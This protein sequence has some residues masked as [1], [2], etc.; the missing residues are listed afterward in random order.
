MAD[1]PN[2]QSSILRR[3]REVIKTF[4]LDVV[5][6]C[7]SKIERITNSS[8]ASRL[9][10]FV[11]TSRQPMLKLVKAL[12][13]CVPLLLTLTTINSQDMQKEAEQAE[14]SYKSVE[15]GLVSAAHQAR[16]HALRQ[17]AFVCT[18][19]V[20]ENTIHNEFVSALLVSPRRYAPYL[21]PAR[22][23][24]IEE[25]QRYNSE[26]NDRPPAEDFALL[27][28]GL[29]RL[30]P[31]GWI[32]GSPGKDTFDTSVNVSW[33][34]E[35]WEKHLATLD[36][37]NSFHLDTLQ[38]AFSQLTLNDLKLPPSSN[39]TGADFEQTTFVAAKLPK[40]DLAAAVLQATDFS[41]TD[42][43]EGH[44]EASQLQGARLAG[45][46]LYGSY[47]NGAYLSSA[48]FQNAQLGGAHLQQAI[49]RGG[50][51]FSKSVLR[52]AELD[53]IDC[54][55]CR[56]AGADLQGASL[57]SALLTGVTFEGA[58]LRNATFR[59]SDLRRVR[60]RHSDLTGADFERVDLRYADFTNVRGVLH[61]RSWRNA[62]IASATGLSAQLK[63]TLLTRFHAVSISS[64]AGWQFYRNNGFPYDGRQN[65]R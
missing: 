41:G 2:K 14:R 55:A 37:Q 54:D 43:E 11:S 6:F 36:N 58:N 34:W 53:Q 30:G 26:R 49:S 7:H 8:A 62:N 25:I 16:V 65:Y 61:A 56:F 57:S 23:L 12:A 42:L 21:D 20:P 33:I 28:E 5:S 47:F 1:P 27:L 50:A 24:F 46:N 9:R 19:S 44:F 31:H 32:K 64:D 48:N 35:P 18:I 60:L 51:D 39:L 59:D 63:N 29:T 45:A 52:S 10:S 38:N 4:V 15:D 22:E 40:V 3:G 13:W 17:L